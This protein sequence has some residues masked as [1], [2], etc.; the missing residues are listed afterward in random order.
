MSKTLRSVGQAR[1]ARPRYPR[2]GLG[3]AGRKCARREDRPD[4]LD[5]ILVYAQSD[6]NM[7]IQN[8]PSTRITPPSRTVQGRGRATGWQDRAA[9]SDPRQ[10]AGQQAWQQAWQPSAGLP[11]TRAMKAPPSWALGQARA[12]PGPPAPRGAERGGAG[13]RTEGHIIH[14]DNVSII[15]AAP[16][17]PAAPAARWQGGGGTPRRGRCG[18]GGAGRRGG[19]PEPGWQGQGQP[20]ANHAAAWNGNQPNAERPKQVNQ[21]SV[22]ICR[23]SSANQA[24]RHQHAGRDPV[25]Q[26]RQSVL[27]APGCAAGRLTQP[28]TRPGHGLALGAPMQEGKIEENP[29]KFLNVANFFNVSILSTYDDI[30][31]MFCINLECLYVSRQTDDIVILS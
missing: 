29:P 21:S 13:L 5:P 14:S 23:P 6:S 28:E 9:G 15:P 17:M 2:T 1:A 8:G 25:P 20:A 10:Q 18:G 26:E 30:Y 12:C 27:R 31:S 4:R 24:R 7:A 3:A 19:A 22:G 16:H 11:V